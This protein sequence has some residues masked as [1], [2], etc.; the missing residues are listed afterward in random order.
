MDH[1][2]EYPEEAPFTISELEQIYPEASARSKVDEEFRQKAL[3]ATSELQDGRP[4]YRALWRHIMNVSVADL[5]ANY[6]KL[7]VSFELWKGESD[8]Q[9]YIP[10]MVRK[11]QEAGFAYVCLNGKPV[12][13]IPLVYGE[14]VEMVSLYFLGLQNHCR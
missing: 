6:D 13:K 8:V 11:M 2:G 5:K 1:T 7:N 3:K 10:D 12:G 14:T 9:K 4:G